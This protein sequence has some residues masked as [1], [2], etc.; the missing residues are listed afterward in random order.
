MYAFQIFC[1]STLQFLCIAIGL[2]IASITELEFMKSHPSWIIYPNST[3]VNFLKVESTWNMHNHVNQMYNIGFISIEVTYFNLQLESVNSPSF[4]WY[5]A[6]V[7][8]LL[9]MALQI[10]AI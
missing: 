9:T 10:H 7:W 2:H 3:D 1:Y 6:C 5:S 4:M 8:R